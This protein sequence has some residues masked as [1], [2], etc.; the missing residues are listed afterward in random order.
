MSERNNNKN[1]R[2]PRFKENKPE[3]DQ[4]IVH[5]ARVTRVMAGGKRMRFRVCLAI[6][7]HQGKVGVGIA[8]GRDV[9][10][11]IQKA[12]HKAEQGMIKVSV[13][14]GTIAHE[15]RIKNGAS[16]ILL[17]PAPAGTGV[18]AGGACRIV[19]SMAGIHNVVAKILGT[20]NKISNAQTTI[21]A[22]QSLKSSGPRRT[23]ENKTEKNLPA[24][25]S[26]TEEPN[27]N[28]SVA[29]NNK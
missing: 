4:Q 3:F 7:D 20:N 18:I 19:L 5:I 17:K 22:L 21:Q 9:P 1:R 6:G 13:V 2:S 27:D 15:V 12:Y 14:E 11:A 16:R 24:Q 10:I 26:K 25:T 29:K 28:K 23:K 8:K